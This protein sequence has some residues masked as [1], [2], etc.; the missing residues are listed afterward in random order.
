V[1]NAFVEDTCVLLV[2]AYLMTRGPLLALL[3]KTHKARRDIFVLGGVFAA[4]ALTGELFPG[5]RYPYVPQTLLVT[6]AT[7]SSGMI[8][9]LVAAGVTAGGALLIRGVPAVETIPSLFAA[10]LITDTVLRVL[11][12]GR[13]MRLADAF[14]SGILA[15]A[16]SFAIHV[17]VSDLL[18][19]SFPALRAAFSIPAN[20]VGVA[21]LQLVVQDA[22]LRADS[23][24]HRHEAEQARVE[25]EQSRALMAETQLAVLRARMHPHFL[26]N[27]LSAIAALCGIAPDR[28]EAAIIR[29]GEMMRRV[30]ASDVRVSVPL[31]QEMADIAGYLE[32][33]Q[34]RLGDR[35][36]MVRDI[37]EALS[38]QTCVPP[39]A[40][41]TLL[42][43]AVSHGIAPKAGAG[44]IGI[45][46]HR[47]RNAASQTLVVVRDDGVGMTPAA[48]HALAKSLREGG[49]KGRI[50]GLALLDQQLRRQFGARARLHLLS[51]PDGGT[52]VAFSIPTSGGMEG[53]QQAAL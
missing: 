50:H 37:D 21:L 10:V 25:I 14:L 29:L 32:I 3:F 18:R 40:L 16:A 26:F 52:L 47:R 19:Q 49:D 53:G 34:Y 45:I 9:G 48:Q 6:F 12:S 31:A 1:I 36:R 22:R 15:Q 27:T 39:F 11:P 7:L 13:R 42:E 51:R 4:V 17:A 8:V 44:T 43:N 30:I 23:E 33:Q 41:M 5:A 20:G 35:L 38:Q 2:I 46:I 24:R 28:A